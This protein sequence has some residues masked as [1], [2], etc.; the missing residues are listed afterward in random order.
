VTTEDAALWVDPEDTAAIATAMQRTA[1]DPTLRETL[2]ER[3]LINVRRFSWA[4]CAR[5]VLDAIE[6]CATSSA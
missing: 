2:A 3:G 1:G 4:A 5:T 6:R